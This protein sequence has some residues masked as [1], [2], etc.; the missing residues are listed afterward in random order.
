MKDTY[1]IDIDNTICISFPV[2]GQFPIKYDYENSTPIMEVIL[3]IQ[4]LYDDGHYIIFHTSRGMK[5]Y[6]KNLD[7]IIKYVKPNLI[8]FLNKYNIKYHELHFGK[9]WNSGNIY[10]VDD[11]NLTLSQFVDGDSK[12]YMK[13]IQKNTEIKN[14]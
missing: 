8:K 14:G 3:K 2:E 7:S 13:Y 5:T 6:D 1:I 9:P 10:I 11:R 4:S 12:T